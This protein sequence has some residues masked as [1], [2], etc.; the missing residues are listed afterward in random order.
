M[1]SSWFKGLSSIL[2]RRN[3]KKVSLRQTSKL[4]RDLYLEPLET[5]L[6]PSNVDFAGGVLGIYLNND[7]NGTVFT[8]NNSASNGQG[9]PVITFTTSAPN[10]WVNGNPGA[11]ANPVPAGITIAG[12]TLRIDTT[13]PELAGLLNINFT[14]AKGGNP[15]VSLIVGSSVIDAIYLTNTSPITRV[16]G[17]G[18]FTAPTTANGQLTITGF[19]ATGSGAVA[20]GSIGF[21]RDDSYFLTP[22]AGTFALGDTISIG[23][24]ANAIITATGATP[25]FRILTP[26]AYLNLRP[27]APFAIVNLVSGGTGTFDGAAQNAYGG[28]VGVAVTNGGTGY[29]NPIAI[30]FPVLPTGAPAGLNFPA[31]A[32]ANTTGFDETSLAGSANIGL[33]VA[34]AGGV[35]DIA[36]NGYL[37]AKGSGDILLNAGA[38]SGSSFSLPSNVFNSLNATSIMTQGTGNITLTANSLTSTVS[39]GSGN[40]IFASGTGSIT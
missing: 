18:Y 14:N 6:N 31:T 5:R 30:G 2:S 11:L 12:Q 23:G 38:L 25:Q 35:W 21:N 15:D 40:K 37:R 10:T 16:A 39:I 34:P 24:S 32:V 17:N 3:K 22:T 19:N 8:V 27:G 29:E 33:S 9:S 20:V 36:V 13:V 7:L 4:H 28:L 26:G 1:A